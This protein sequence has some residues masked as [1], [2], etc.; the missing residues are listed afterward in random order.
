M[1]MI[2]CKN[3]REYDSKDAQRI[4]QSITLEGFKHKLHKA[5]R[6][7][8]AQV[9]KDLELHIRLDKGLDTVVGYLAELNKIQPDLVTVSLTEDDMRTFNNLNKDLVNASQDD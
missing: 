2:V 6:N 5:L 8:P 4:K 3:S 1:K 9:Q 7:P